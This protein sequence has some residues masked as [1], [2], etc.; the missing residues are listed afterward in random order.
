MRVGGGGIWSRLRNVNNSQIISIFCFVTRRLRRS[1]KTPFAAESVDFRHF[2]VLLYYQMYFFQRNELC[3]RENNRDGSGK[4]NRG[5]SN[6]QTRITRSACL[7]R[8]PHGISDGMLNGN[9]FKVKCKTILH[10]KRKLLKSGYLFRFFF[11]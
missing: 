5:R 6:T 4:G 8:V 9:G 10:R 2:P 11:L 1:A 7:R 3:G